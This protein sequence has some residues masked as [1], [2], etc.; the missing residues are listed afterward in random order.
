MGALIVCPECA[1]EF[2]ATTEAVTSGPREV[3]DAGYAKIC[4][5]AQAVV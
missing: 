4:S 1:H 5:L 3:R 2:E